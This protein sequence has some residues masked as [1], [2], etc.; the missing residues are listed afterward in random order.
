MATAEE[1]GFIKPTGIDYIKNGDNAISKNADVTALELSALDYKLADRVRAI[2]EQTGGRIENLVADPLPM[3]APATYLGGRCTIIQAP[4]FGRATCNAAG[5]TYFTAKSSLFAEPNTYTEI[6]PGQKISARIELRGQTTAKLGASLVVLGHRWD[7]S[8]FVSQTTLASTAL[9]ELNTDSRV[10]VLTAEGIVPLDTD[11]THVRMQ[12]QFRRWGETYPQVGD[13]LYFRKAALYAGDNAVSANTYVDGNADNS[14]WTG[15]PNESTSVQLIGGSKSDDGSAAYR[16]DTIVDAGIKRRGG[17]IGT[18]GLPAVALRFDHHLPDFKSKVLP[19]LK[20][21]RLPWGQMLNPANIANGN[22]GMTYAQF[23]AEAYNTGGEAW[24]HSYSHSNISN[25]TEADREITQGFNDLTAGLPGLYIDGWAGPGQPELMGMEGSDTPERFWGTYPGRLVLARHAFV[26]GYY[27]GIYQPMSGPNLVG[28]PHTTIDTLDDTYVSGI[29]RG[30]ISAKAGLTL[31]LH[32]NYLDTAGY[33]T[34]AQLDKILA[35]L[36][37]SRDAGELL[38]L[39]PTAILL[40]DSSSDYRRNLLTTG[41]AGSK[42]GT[43]SETVSSRTDQAQYGVPHELVVT[44]RAK[45]AGTVA[46]N[47]K[48]TG[49][50]RFDTAHSVTLA[51]GAVATLRCLATLPLDCAGILA[52]LTGNIDHSD[53]E[54]HAV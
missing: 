25:A 33:M 48:E 40:T 11:L 12:V 37:K 29:V 53:I 35:D 17:I 46:L 10:V 28:A 45:T 31:M 23:A 41:G 49:V 43:W 39:S 54:L 13:I 36:A 2:E 18:N 4:G 26:R 27:P 1:L 6:K 15:K 34:T 47:L 50:P 3:N 8:T 30:A 38:I 7:G 16:R 24:H 19:L 44:V 52:Q 14:Y 22:E 9:T 51:A 42:N 5:A 32:P 20:Q 21:Y